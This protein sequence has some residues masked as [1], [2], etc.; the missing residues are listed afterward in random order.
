[1]LK[2]ILLQKKDS[3][4]TLLE[5]M[6]VVSILAVMMTYLATNLTKT[7]DSAM[8]DT[9]KMG[10]QQIMQP[11]QMYK[12]HNKT[13]PNDQQGL[14][15]LVTN[16]GNAKSWRGPYIEKSKLKDPWDNPFRY[17]LENGNPKL[18]S[19]GPDGQEGTEDDIE[20]PEA[21]E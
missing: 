16:P 15:A 14:D 12:L 11:L 19:N 4:M 1:M 6:I 5:I 7:Q 9:A 3:G 21:E 20:F 8:I 2:K 10:M 17:S 18:Y 13:Y